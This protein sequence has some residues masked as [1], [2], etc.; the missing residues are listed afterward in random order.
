MVVIGLVG[1]IAA[2]KSTVAQAFADSGVEVIDADRLAHAALADPEAVARIVG[3]FGADLLDEA[4]RVRRPV[5]AERVFGPTAEQDAA[6]RDLEAIVHPLVRRRIEERLAE[7]GATEQGGRGTLVVLDV[8]LLMQAGWDRLC[9]RIVAVHCD[10]A[11]RQR[12]LEAR[13]WSIAQRAAR[14]R[15]WERHYRPPPAEKTSI[16]DASADLAY[17]T[18]QVVRILE[19]IEASRG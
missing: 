11:V 4:G 8:P 12:R 6:L 17:T 10:E 1:K 5:L 14:E 2:G 7:I 15:A 19:A 16:V 18:A 3:R 9:D 13:G